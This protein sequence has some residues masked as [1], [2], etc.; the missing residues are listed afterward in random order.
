MLC[1]ARCVQQQRLSQASS[2]LCPRA[3]RERCCAL[4]CVA[5]RCGL[6]FEPTPSTAWAPPGRGRSLTGVR[7]QWLAC[8]HCGSGIGALGG[9]LVHA[10]LHSASFA[11][12]HSC[13]K[14]PFPFCPQAL[15]TA[16]PGAAWPPCTR[17]CRC[18]T[19]PQRRRRRRRGCLG[20]GRRRQRRRRRQLLR[21]PRRP[22]RPPPPVR[23]CLQ[24]GRH[25]CQG[26]A[27][28]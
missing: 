18:P 16:S 23:A 24:L 1:A 28:L 27:A 2:W 6:R 26:L 5:A 15:A 7:S 21:Q 8:S 17:W 10:L 9:R 11:P 25:C 22:R 19:S 13:R 12:P 14:P 3:D 4:P 20:W